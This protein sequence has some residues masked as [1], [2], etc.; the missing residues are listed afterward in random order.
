VISS[1]RHRSK[2]AAL[3]VAPMLL[4]MAAHMA[5][6]PA[7][8]ACGCVAPPD[9]ATP[10]VQAG[11]RIVFYVEDGKVTA[12]IQ[13][14]YA[15]PAEEFGW[16][17]PVPSVPE[18]RL[19]SEDLFTQI[20]P[21]TQ[22]LYRTDTEF[23]GDCFG[24]EG[25][26]TSTGGSDSGGDGDGDGDSDGGPGGSPVIL[27]ESVGPFDLVALR[28]DD[29][30]EMFNW[31]SD[32]GFFVPAG[33]D[34]A[35]DPYINEGA[36][37]VAVKLL[38]GEDAGDIQPLVV[39]Y[40]SDLP[41]IPIILTSVAADPDMGVQVW[42]VGEDR[43]IP[44]NYRHTEINDA[45]IDWLNFGQNY[46]QVVTDAVDEAEGHHSFVTEYAGTSNVMVDVLDAPG[47]FGN[48]ETLAGL[49]DPVQFV[50]YLRQNQYAYFDNVF[51]SEFYSPQLI[52]ILRGQLPIPPN[53]AN[54]GV[55]ESDYYLFFDYYINE[56][57]LQ[58]PEL[59]ED[60][61]LDYDAGT[62]AAEINERYVQPTLEA[63]QM[64]RDFSYMTRLFTTLSPEEMTKDP[65]FSFNPDLPDVSQRH[66]GLLT[67][68]CDGTGAPISTQPARLTTEQGYEI[69][70]PDGTGGAR[71]GS[72]VANISEMPQSTFIDILREAGDPDREVDNVSVIQ[73]LL[74][75][76]ND[77]RCEDGACGSADGVPGA[78]DGGGCGCAAP[79]DDA[80]AGGLAVLGL[81]AALLLRRRRR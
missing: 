2:R 41:M 12:H 69:W 66:E 49:T 26:G 63:G 75:E 21:V 17:I 53:L 71:P 55:S 34:D 59:F 28:G 3:V 67:V 18:F 62:L 48:L 6:P 47:R 31:L 16:L 24:D 45:A 38:S 61:D 1:V 58:Q 23:V 32:N 22:P 79:G 51:F 20:L 68:F 35:V 43:A 25:A 29:K 80:P 72:P 8:R 60:L 30:E 44:R 46:P 7:A 57:R 78:P 4:A 39:E 27:R 56:L 15:G 54:W 52:A 5:A 81:G 37:F 64:F 65:V 73:Q 50:T 70:F 33:T 19:G 9:P 42:I 77:R 76:E 36:H 74:Q 40:E 10:V 13:I 14:Q 11:E